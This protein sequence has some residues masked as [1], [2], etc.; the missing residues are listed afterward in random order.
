MLYASSFVGTAETAEFE[1]GTHLNSN[2]CWLCRS[3][4]RLERSGGVV[5]IEKGRGKPRDRSCWPALRSTMASYSCL[6]FPCAADL[7]Q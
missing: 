3:S 5:A 1:V 7:G 6:Q 2:S 4:A